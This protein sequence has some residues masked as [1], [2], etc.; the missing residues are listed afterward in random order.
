MFVTVRSSQRKT[1]RNPT[2]VLHHKVNATM[3]PNN[4]SHHLNIKVNVAYRGAPPDLT[5]PLTY[6]ITSA[7]HSPSIRT[8]FN[9]RTSSHDQSTH[10]LSPRLTSSS[11]QYPTSAVGSTIGTSFLM[12]K[13]SIVTQ[14]SARRC[15]MS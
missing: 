6:S 4:E 9:Q 13:D 7:A 3:D 11:S 2:S 1:Q 12:L 10:D 5:S 8:S 15:L 14:R